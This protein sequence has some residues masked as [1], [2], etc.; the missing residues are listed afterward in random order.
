M[1]REKKSSKI[2]EM[3]HKNIPTIDKII[4]RKQYKSITFCLVIG[5]KVIGVDIQ[6]SFIDNK[7]FAEIESYFSK[8][9]IYHSILSNSEL[10]MCDHNGVFTYINDP[11]CRDMML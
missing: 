7:T 6:K 5:D 8:R 1:N 10:K 3:F 2:E 9:H 11:S 4:K